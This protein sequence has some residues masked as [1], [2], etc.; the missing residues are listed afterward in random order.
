MEMKPTHR[1]LLLND[2]G[3]YC[4]IPL[5]EQNRKKL[6]TEEILEQNPPE[7]AS[8]FEQMKGLKPCQPEIT[9]IAL[10]SIDKQANQLAI[11]QAVVVG[12]AIYLGACS[13]ADYMS[14]K[15]YES[16]RTPF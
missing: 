4:V 14:N 8:A 3:N 7:Q 9:Q 2:N 13:A 5:N 16:S 15:R 11:A 1:F 6:N 10:N 12:G